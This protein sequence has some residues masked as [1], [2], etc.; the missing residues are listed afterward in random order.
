MLN[1][2]LCSFQ[3]EAPVELAVHKFQD[4]AFASARHNSHASRAARP[5]PR[6]SHGCNL[7]LTSVGDRILPDRK[8]EAP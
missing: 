4:S 7:N 8:Q 3:G 1:T 5:R 6:E 2:F